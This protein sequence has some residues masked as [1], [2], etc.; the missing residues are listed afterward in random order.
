MPPDHDPWLHADEE[1]CDEAR[2]LAGEVI[3]RMLVWFADAPT[4]LDRGLRATVALHCLRP[5]LIGT[6]TLDRI[7]DEAAR[8]RQHVHALAKQFKLLMGDAT[9][10]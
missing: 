10:P 2:E 7:G 3:R 1:V 4:M 5:D 8:T 6:P 9:Q